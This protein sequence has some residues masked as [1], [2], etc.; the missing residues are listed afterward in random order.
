MSLPAR[1]GVAGVVGG[2]AFVV[3][4]PDAGGEAGGVGAAGTLGAFSR[5]NGGSCTTEAME[6][7][8]IG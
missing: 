5:A 6:G 7:G 2:E 8:E 1:A 4:M 3:A